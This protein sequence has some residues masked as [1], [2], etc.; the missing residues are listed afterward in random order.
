MISSRKGF[1]VAVLPQFASWDA[2]PPSW[3]VD[4]LMTREQ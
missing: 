4:A 3:H 1:Y 2:P